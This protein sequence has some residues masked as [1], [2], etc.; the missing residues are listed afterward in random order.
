MFRKA[1]KT[2]TP[3]VIGTLAGLL[4][5]ALVWGLQAALKA[6]IPVAVGTLAAFVFAMFSKK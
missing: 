6:V 5:V 3:Y 1:L 4:F 2:I